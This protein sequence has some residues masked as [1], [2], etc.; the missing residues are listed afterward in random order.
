M[1]RLARV[2]ARSNHSVVL[3]LV[4]AEKC[5]DCPANCNKPLIDLFSL[6]KNLFTLSKNNRNYQLIDGNG[7]LSKPT[8]LDEL[9]N[10]EID[11]DDLVKSSALLYLLPLLTCLLFLTIGHFAGLYWNLSTDLMALLGF[12]LGLAVI[13]LLARRKNNQQHLKFR[14]KVTIL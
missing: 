1:N 8:L 6:R 13:Y 5:A 3:N 12:I 4:Q 11:T 7:L 14:P 2:I 9:I 10:I